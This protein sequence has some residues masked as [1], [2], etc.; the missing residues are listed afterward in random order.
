M[1]LD[2]LYTPAPMKA[3]EEVS[4]GRKLWVSEQNTAPLLAAAGAVRRC[5]DEPQGKREISRN[6]EI[7]FAAA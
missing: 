6:L 1:F 3:P 4:L 2:I 5:R 7:P